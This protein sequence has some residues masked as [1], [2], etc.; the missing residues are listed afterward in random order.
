MSSALRGRLLSSLALVL[1]AVYAVRAVG[2]W[3]GGYA[4]QRASELVADEAY[5]EALPYLRWA[6]AGTK[7]AAA[8]WLR[9]MAL[10]GSWQEQVDAGVPAAELREL[11]TRARN[12]YLRAISL[13]PAS[14]WYWTSL[15][16]LY[17]FLE[18]LERHEQGFVLDALERGPWGLVGRAGRIA[19]GLARIGIA[20]EP[21]V[22]LFHDRLAFML[23]AFRLDELALESVRDSARAQPIYWLHDYRNLLEPPPELLDTFARAARAALGQTPFTPRAVHLLALGRIE[24]ERGNLEQAEVDLRAALEAPGNRSNRGEIQFQLGVVLSDLERYDEA[25]QAFEAARTADAAFEAASLA[26]MARIAEA[27]GRMEEALGLLRQVCRLRPRDLEQTLALTRVARELERWDAAEAALRWAAVIH[28]NDP[29][30]LAER[31]RILA[32][33]RDSI[34]AGRLL[35]EFGSRFGEDDL[36]FGELRALVDE[37]SAPSNV[38]GDRERTTAPAGGI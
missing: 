27:T 20:R 14:G 5:D 30:P 21:T 25:W 9:G 19:V 2:G 24:H 13:A 15:A 29:R 4:Y 3:I 28:P 35:E 34:A 10:E 26:G 22:Y 32:A 37:G 38:P 7:F 23:W 17:Y 6:G 1:L 8:A 33:R 18:R 31:I 12:E 11:A 36:L 16:D